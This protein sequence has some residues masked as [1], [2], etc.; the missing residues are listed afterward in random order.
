ML[1][2]GAIKGRA[3]FVEQWFTFCTLNAVKSHF[4]QFV[5][6]QATVDFRQYSGDEP[7]LADRDDGIQMVRGGPQGAALSWINFS[8][9]GI[10]A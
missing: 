5:R 3:D 9:D 6:F 7:F 2:V 4:D 1:H 10:V 8:H